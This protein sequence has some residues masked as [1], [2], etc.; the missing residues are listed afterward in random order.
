MQYYVKIFKEAI[1]LK[2]LEEKVHQWIE[3]HK[4]KIKVVSIQP[5]GTGRILV[6]YEADRLVAD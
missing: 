6:C 3:K 5:T 1:G 2:A 4:D